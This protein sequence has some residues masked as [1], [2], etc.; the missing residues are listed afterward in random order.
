[1]HYAVRALALFPLCTSLSAC[2][3]AGWLP[4]FLQSGPHLQAAQLQEEPPPRIIPAAFVQTV[5]VTEV[6]P[7]FPLK[8]LK[9]TKKKLTASPTQR[10]AAANS[11]ALQEPST[12]GYLNAIQIYNYTDGALYRL[13][14]APQEVSDIALQPGENL[15]AISAG[16]T[17]RWVV[18]D[19]TS[20]NGANKQVHI[21]AKPYAS[22]LKTNLVITT[23]RRSYH[24]E[25]QSTSDTFMAAVSW[26]YPQDNLVKTVPTANVSSSPTDGL[27]AVENLHFGYSI[28]GDNVAWKPVRAFDDGTRVYIEFPSALG[29]RTASVRVRPQ[30]RSRSCQ[31]PGSRQ[32]LCCRSA[33]LPGRASSRTRPSAGRE[34]QADNAASDGRG[35]VWSGAVA[36]E[37]CSN[38]GRGRKT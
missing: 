35:Q 33:L 29:R 3:N 15:T 37:R 5:P 38:P 26:N 11:A 16:D 17:S 20:G 28:S 22:G 27:P 1:M 7:K 12:D 19:T 4:S 24:L 13:F 10:V 36:H 8:P 2:A 34:D 21:L 23:D 25:L 6:T 30:W 9:K 18:G 32:L 31:L 14:A